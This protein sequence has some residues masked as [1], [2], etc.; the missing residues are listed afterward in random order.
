M[1]SSGKLNGR[2]EVVCAAVDMIG[3]RER[4]RV[5]TK[6]Q[7]PAIPDLVTHAEDTRASG[8]SR[9]FEIGIREVAGVLHAVHDGFHGSADHRIILEQS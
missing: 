9:V 6:E 5:R 3:V 7:M 4:V 2:A 8:K 1:N